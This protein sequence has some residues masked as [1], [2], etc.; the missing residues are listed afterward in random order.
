MGIASKAVFLFVDRATETNVSIAK[1]DF[2]KVKKVKKEMIGDFPSVAV[3]LVDRK[4]IQYSSKIPKERLQALI[5]DNKYKFSIK[6]KVQESDVDNGDCQGAIYVTGKFKSCE[7]RKPCF[8]TP[9]NYEPIT[10]RL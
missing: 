9:I 7:W 1:D 4:M 10:Y 3:R 5:T 2:S 6:M 8:L